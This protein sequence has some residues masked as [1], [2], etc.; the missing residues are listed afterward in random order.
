MDVRLQDLILKDTIDLSANIMNFSLLSASNRTNLQHRNSTSN[1]NLR[2][3]RL[4]AIMI[5]T[6]M[7]QNTRLVHG[8]N[9]YTIV[10]LM[11]RLMINKLNVT[12]SN[13]TKQTLMRM[14]T[15]I[16]SLLL[17]ILRLSVRHINLIP[18]T[19]NAPRQFRRNLTIRHIL[20]QMINILLNMNN[21]NR[22]HIL[23]RIHNK[24][25][26]KISINTKLNRRINRTLVNVRNGLVNN[27][28]ILSNFNTSN[29]LNAKV[30]LSLSHSHDQIV[31]RIHRLIKNRNRLTTRMRT[32]T[33][34]AAMITTILIPCSKSVLVIMTRIICHRMIP[35]KSFSQI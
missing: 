35:A 21:A 16:I 13:L 11:L 31:S 12:K 3:D 34:E 7:I 20:N 33:D 22:I 29:G 2:Q 23:N 18:K 10:L 1:H 24:L 32:M 9:P 4:S 15:S 28:R 30:I 14:R 17:T 25:K 6:H 5:H 27:L 26:N 8:Q 19:L